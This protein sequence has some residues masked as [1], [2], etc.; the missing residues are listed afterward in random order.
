MINASLGYGGWS[1]CHSHIDLPTSDMKKHGSNGSRFPMPGAHSF[2]MGNY[3]LTQ[4]NAFV[5]T[6]P[7]FL[8]KEKQWLIPNKV[9][10]IAWVSENYSTIRMNLPY[11]NKQGGDIPDEMYLEY[12]AIRER[13][14]IIFKPF[15]S[16]PEPHTWVRVSS[17]GMNAKDEVLI[18]HNTEEFFSDVVVLDYV[19]SDR[20]NVYDGYSGEYLQSA[21]ILKELVSTLPNK[22]ATLIHS[23]DFLPLNNEKLILGTHD[24]A[25]TESNGYDYHYDNPNNSRTFISKF[26]RTFGNCLD[27]VSDFVNGI[28]FNRKYM[29]SFEGGDYI[30]YSTY[31]FNKHKFFYCQDTK[32]FSLDA[33]KVYVDKGKNFVYFSKSYNGAKLCSVSNEY[34][35]PSLMVDDVSIFELMKRLQVEWSFVVDDFIKR[36]LVFVYDDVDALNNFLDILSKKT[37]YRWASG[38]LPNEYHFDTSKAIVFADGV[39]KLKSIDDLDGFKIVDVKNLLFKS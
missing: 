26:S 38:K 14:A 4:G 32:L 13:M 27:L 11:P 9:R 29:L 2:W 7:P 6:E 36:N 25:L 37:P 19:S 30:S 20:S 8:V 22:K 5:I 31:L 18:K 16:L 15:V 34:Y 3:Q 21:S 17:H 10:T 24:E 28:S 39:L 1:S 23:S 33:M 12:T 35:L